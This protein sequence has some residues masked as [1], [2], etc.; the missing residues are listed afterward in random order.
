[1]KLEQMDIQKPQ[2]IVLINFTNIKS[3][4]ITDLKRKP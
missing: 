2:N 3:E 1:V 4:W